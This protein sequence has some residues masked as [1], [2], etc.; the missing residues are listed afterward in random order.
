MQVRHRRA[1]RRDFTAL[2]ELFASCG[3]PIPDPNRSTLSRFRKIVADLGSDIYVATEREAIIGLVHTTYSR[4]L[5]A[6]TRAEVATL[7][8]GPEHRRRGVGKALLALA[9]ERARRRHCS[10]L[11]YLPESD[12]QAI[13]GL[14][15][16]AG[17]T[18]AG[19]LFRVDLRPRAGHSEESPRN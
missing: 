10:E 7:L 1:R 12:P 15:R 13:E 9:H 16:Q 11:R 17:W 14:L 6:G 5:T 2:T 3:F 8:V 4:S 19:S 18:V